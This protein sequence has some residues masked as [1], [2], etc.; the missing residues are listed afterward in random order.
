MALGPLRPMTSGQKHRYV[1]Q[2]YQLERP[3]VVCCAAILQRVYR[4]LMT[5]NNLTRDVRHFSGGFANSE[6]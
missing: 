5:E 1:I 2:K 3:S 6:G 4:V